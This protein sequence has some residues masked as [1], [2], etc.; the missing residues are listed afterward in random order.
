MNG[1]NPS[2]KGI[3]YLNEQ[4]RKYT[5]YF[6]CQFDYFGGV[7]RFR[8]WGE[9]SSAGAALLSTRS[10]QTTTKNGTG[11]SVPPNSRTKHYLGVLAVQRC[12]V[13]SSV[14]TVMVER[15]SVVPA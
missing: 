7:E 11:G 2:E 6:T 3:P 9:Y 13:V 14:S 8:I 10:N 15:E 1:S 4:W 12:S 5:L